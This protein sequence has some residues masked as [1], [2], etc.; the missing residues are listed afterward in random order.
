MGWWV[1]WWCWVV[2]HVWAPQSVL[3]NQTSTCW[4][5]GIVHCGCSCIF[6]DS[7]KAC[8]YLRKIRVKF[9]V[10]GCEE[11]QV[12]NNEEKKGDKKEEKKE[13]K[14]FD[15][16]TFITAIFIIAAVCTIAGTIAGCYKC[17]KDRQA[18]LHQQL[19]VSASPSPPPA[20]PARVSPGP[21]RVTLSDEESDRSSSPAKPD[22]IPDFFMMTGEELEQYMRAQPQLRVTLK[23]CD[24][25]MKRPP[26]TPLRR[27][28]RLTMKQLEE[29]REDLTWISDSRITI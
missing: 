27:S 14:G 6:S 10:F 13:K 24:K 16:E 26:P 19:P 28:K 22:S 3:I 11:W 2:L 9:T 18:R 29:R 5:T 20:P 1:W 7:A 17:Y 25:L 8:L 12:K 15:W 21:S 23:K 4:S